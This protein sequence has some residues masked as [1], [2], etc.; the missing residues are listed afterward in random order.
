MVHTP[1]HD[2]PC[3]TRWSHKMLR[4]PRMKKVEEP[5]PKRV[6]KKAAPSVEPEVAEEPVAVEAELPPGEPVSEEVPPLP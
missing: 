1:A 5:K 3:P 6:A 2:V 4:T